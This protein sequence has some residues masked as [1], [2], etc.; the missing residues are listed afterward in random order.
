MAA[1]PLAWAAFA[2]WALLIFATVPFAR[3]IEAFVVARVGEHAFLVVVLAIVGAAALLAWRALAR[4]G[5]RARITVAAGVALYAATAWWLRANPVESV[6]VVEYGVLGL[7]ALRALAHGGRDALL[8]PCAALLG[9][10]VGLVD[11]ALQWLAPRRVWDLRDVLIN[12]LA[13]AGGPAL[14]ALA[15]APAAWS[16]GAPS[17]ASVRRGLALAALAWALLGA[18]LL[19]TSA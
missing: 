1:A 7:L 16:R 10:T 18:S 12:A 6:H 13:A 19:N 14:I 3:A 9:L 15:A 5:A 8:A 2:S 11:E 4:L 17:R